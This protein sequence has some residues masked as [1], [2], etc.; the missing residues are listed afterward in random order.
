MKNGPNLGRRAAMQSCFGIAA[1]LLAGHT[2]AF[3]DLE[4]DAAGRIYRRYALLI[5]GQRDDEVGIG[6]TR[7]AVQVLASSLTDSRAQLARAADCRRVGL[8]IGTEQRD[9]AIMPVEGADALLLAKSPFEDLRNVPLRS[10]VSFG[11]HL[12]VCR[13]DFIGRHAYLLAKT[14]TEHHDALPAPVR[15]PDGLIPLHPGAAAY[16]SGELAPA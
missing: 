2:P 3:A 16:F 15:R 6:L 11:T 13:T 8:L 12:L 5:V 10:I 1:F 14:L 4:L 9:L 7:A